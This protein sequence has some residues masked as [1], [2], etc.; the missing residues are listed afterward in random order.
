MTTLHEESKDEQLCAK[1]KQ[2][3]RKHLV[4]VKPV[5]KNLALFES[6]SNLPSREVYTKTIGM[7][8][9]AQKLPPEFDLKIRAI[10]N[11]TKTLADI[12]N[13]TSMA[14]AKVFIEDNLTTMLANIITEGDRRKQPI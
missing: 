14:R 7:V 12:A 3:E 1:A 8:P 5:V 6:F 2:I 11:S 9:V 4:S 10:F 13:D